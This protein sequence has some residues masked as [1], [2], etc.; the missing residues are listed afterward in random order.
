MT[1]NISDQGINCCCWRLPKLHSKT[2]I[3]ASARMMMEARASNYKWQMHGPA[4]NGCTTK[5]S[6]WRQNSIKRY[7]MRQNGMQLDVRRLWRDFLAVTW[8]TSNPL[9]TSS[10]ESYNPDHVRIL[11]TQDSPHRCRQWDDDRAGW[12]E[13][14]CFKMPVSSS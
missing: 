13:I 3:A 6:S 12:V 8:E 2:G 4:W 1:L 7:N 9:L 14:Y 5:R 10:R 11:P